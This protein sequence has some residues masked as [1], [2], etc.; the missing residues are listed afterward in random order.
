MIDFMLM[1]TLIVAFITLIV[2]LVVVL[3]GSICVAIYLIREILF[4]DNGRENNF[5]GDD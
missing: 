3:T 1:A 4:S 2:F 5:N